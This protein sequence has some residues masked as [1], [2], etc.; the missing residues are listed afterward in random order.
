MSSD[1]ISIMSGKYRQ[2][3]QELD[4]ESLLEMDNLTSGGTIEEP[5]LASNHF[6][7]HS[8]RYWSFAMHTHL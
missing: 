4:P 8:E 5:T 3:M 2:M 6:I 7:S 1:L